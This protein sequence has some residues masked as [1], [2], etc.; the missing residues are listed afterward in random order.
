VPASTGAF[1]GVVSGLPTRAEAE[2]PLR[3][4]PSRKANPQLFA[5]VVFAGFTAHGCARP[6][7]LWSSFFESDSNAPTSP[8]LRIDD[9]SWKT[10]YA[11]P[12]VLVCRYS[13]VESFHAMPAD[14]Q[15]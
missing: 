5:T 10:T 12:F 11:Q 6:S 8:L 15:P 9:G 14:P 2:N 1:V 3:A 4:R 7:E 13:R